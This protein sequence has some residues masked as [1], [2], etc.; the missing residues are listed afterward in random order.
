VFTDYPTLAA[1]MSVCPLW[2]RLEFDVGFYPCC[3][4]GVADAPLISG[5]DS[6]VVEYCS[7]IVS[8]VVTTF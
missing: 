2:R 5:N 3:R 4:P 7:F 1:Q 6:A 8:P